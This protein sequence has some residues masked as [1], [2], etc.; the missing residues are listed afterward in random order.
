MKY[1]H[2]RQMNIP[3]SG[4]FA[5]VISSRQG[6]TL[7][8]VLIFLVI[9]SFLT[10]PIINI[11]SYSS[12]TTAKSK[13]AMIA[14]NL[15]A[16]TI[17]EIRGMKF[18]DVNNTPWD[19][20]NG[21]WVSDTNVKITY[22]EEYKIFQKQITVKT[23]KDLPVNNANLKQ[24]VV[25]IKWDEMTDERKTITHNSIKLATYIAKENPND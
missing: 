8:F 14:L 21:E 2:S 17:E 12:Q 11:F 19:S 15:A 9:L 5:S 4:R 18:A 1:C 24:V 13:N 10:I 25:N 6:N 20:F 22:P 23:G 3:A 16:Q 7:A